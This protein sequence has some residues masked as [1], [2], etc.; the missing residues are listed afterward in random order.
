MKT[1]DQ[2]V[3]KAILNGAHSYFSG[4]SEYRGAHEFVDAVEF[5]YE[6]DRDSFMNDFQKRWDEVMKKLS[7]ENWNADNLIAY[8]KKRLTD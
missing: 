8:L 2:V 7:E 5:I 1:Y 4:S 3:N 6:V